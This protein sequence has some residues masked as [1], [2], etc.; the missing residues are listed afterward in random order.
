M[1]IVDKDIVNAELSLK[2]IKLEK[3]EKKKEP[4]PLKTEMGDF[5]DPW[6]QKKAKD[7]LKQYSMERTIRIDFKIKNVYFK[8][9]SRDKEGKYEYNIFSVKWPIFSTE[10]INKKI[11]KG[12]YQTYSWI[13]SKNSKVLIDG[14]GYYFMQNQLIS[15]WY[16]DENKVKETHKT[17]NL[18]IKV[19]DQKMTLASVLKTDTELPADKPFNIE[20]HCIYGG[21]LIAA[22]RGWAWYPFDSYSAK[23]YIVFPF[24]E[25]D[26]NFTIAQADDFDVRIKSSG[27]KELENFKLEQNKDQFIE[28]ILKRKDHKLYWGIVLSLFFCLLPTFIPKLGDVFWARI[29][30]YLAALCSVFFATFPPENIA[31]FFPIR[32]LLILMTILYAIINEYIYWIRSIAGK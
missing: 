18:I 12:V 3:E 2:F 1:S 28:I 32:F 16:G 15:D 17:E 14:L 22:Q 30:T 7:I 13:S 26:L 10:I 25:T 20:G 6:I 11:N 31:M 21:S 19:L 29:I 23:L 27:K 4:L 8:S 5:E 24:K 9:P